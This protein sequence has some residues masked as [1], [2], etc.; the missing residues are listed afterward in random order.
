MREE[1]TALHTCKSPSSLK[2]LEGNGA[3]LHNN[4]TNPKLQ[5]PQVDLTDDTTAFL[6]FGGL[7]GLA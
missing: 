4:P 2:G 5:V 6:S 1:T 3:P 7:L